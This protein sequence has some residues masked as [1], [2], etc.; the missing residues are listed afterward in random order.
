[1]EI[2]GFTNSSTVNGASFGTLQVEQKTQNGISLSGDAVNISDEAKELYTQMQING[3]PESMNKEEF[4]AFLA[5]NPEAAA[6]HEAH[7]NEEG[8]AQGTPPQGGQA[9]Q[10]GGES[11]K[12]GQSGGG[13]N[14][15][16]G[17]SSASTT[18]ST[19]TETELESQITL[20]EAQI[21]QA[22]AEAEESGN[23]AQVEAL[24]A[25]LKTLEDELSDLEDA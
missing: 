13:G 5:E 18:E 20:L 16:G 12:G 2:N 7:M 11:S 3:G 8:K 6:L 24:E 10:D 4:E 17:S 23:N 1:M 14:Q 25:Q 9:K 21:A 15:Q 19:T 22:E